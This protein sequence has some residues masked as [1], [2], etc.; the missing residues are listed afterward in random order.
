VFKGCESK[1]RDVNIRIYSYVRYLNQLG[2][3]SSYKNDSGH[4][5]AIDQRQD[6]QIQK[7]SIYFAGWFHDPRFRCFH[8]TWT[9]IAS[10]G[11]VAQVVLAGNL[12]Y[13]INRNF[14]LM[15]GIMLSLPGVRTSE[16]NYPFWLSVDNRM[17]GDEFHPRI[18]VP[19]VCRSLQGR[20]LSKHEDIR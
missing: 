13:N 15:N 4:T 16:G 20:L 17:I 9:C 3:D 6:V 7:V 11:L 10:Q 14:A 19:E 1:Y 5:S 8:Y 18:L 12:V 2:L